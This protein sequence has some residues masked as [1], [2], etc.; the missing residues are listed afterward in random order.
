V[1]LHSLF[2]VVVDVD[3]DRGHTGKFVYTEYCVFR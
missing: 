3:R 1:L 2:E